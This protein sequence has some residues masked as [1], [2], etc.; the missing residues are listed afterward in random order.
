[1]TP[2][3]IITLIIGGGF[4]GFL[5]AMVTLHYSRRKTKAEV[6]NII[7][8]TEAKRVKSYSDMLNQID[9]LR[10][11]NK[12]LFVEKETTEQV[13]NKLDERLTRMQETME[14]LRRELQTEREGKMTMAREIIQ[15]RET[16][17]E[18]ESHI[19]NQ[20]IRIEGLEALVTQHERT[21]AGYGKDIKTIQT[22]NLNPDWNKK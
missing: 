17:S 6:E 5:G 21:I 7:A 11:Q 13:K 1:M 20:N 3:E 16:N 12:K 18:R 19:L 22:G 9:E 8:D 15:L 10:E 2:T 4:F 14:M